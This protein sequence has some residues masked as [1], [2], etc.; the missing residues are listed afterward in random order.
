MFRPQKYT[1]ARAGTGVA[2]T[3]G[4]AHLRGTRPLPA[5]SSVK[6]TAWRVGILKIFVLKK[7]FE[8]FPIL[9]V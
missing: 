4:G 3:G 2:G 5:P 9:L 6:N 7:I 8:D 1:A